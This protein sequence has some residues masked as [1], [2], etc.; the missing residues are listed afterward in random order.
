M[1]VQPANPIYFS[2]K[3]AFLVGGISLRS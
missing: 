3:I 1:Q 2:Y